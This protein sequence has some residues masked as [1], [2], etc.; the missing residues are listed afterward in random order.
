MNPIDEA[1]DV[2][3]TM[4]GH[5]DGMYVQEFKKLKERL[6]AIAIPKKVIE[7]HIESKLERLKKVRPMTEFITGCITEL[8]ALRIELLNNGED[9]N[10]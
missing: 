3:L 2:F 8:E 7:E 6:N 5:P 10:G 1:I 4:Y 9:K